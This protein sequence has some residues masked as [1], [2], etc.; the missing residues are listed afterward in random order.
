LFRRSGDGF[1]VL[2]MMQRAIC[3]KLR[4]PVSAIDFRMR[5]DAERI[6]PLAKKRELLAPCSKK[7]LGL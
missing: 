4:R 6:F 5:L 2:A 7:I 1:N 3:R